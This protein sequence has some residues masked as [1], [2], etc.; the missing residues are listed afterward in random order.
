MSSD[1]QVHMGKPRA[2]MFFRPKP[3]G[4]IDPAGEVGW[5][6][7]R[8]R[9]RRRERLHD[10]GRASGVHPHH[11]DAIEAGDLTRLPPRRDTLRMLE[12]YALHLGFDPEPLLKHYA[13][14]LPQQNRTTTRRMPG[15]A[16]PFGSAEII[17]FPL[18]NRLIDATKGNG[19]IVA[20]ICGA[21]FLFAAASWVLSP[22]SGSSGEAQALRSAPSHVKVEGPATEVSSITSLTEELMKGDS[23]ETRDAAV[24]PVSPDLP[25]PDAEDAPSLPVDGIA[26][27]IARETGTPA[28]RNAAA[29]RAPES[30]EQAGGG[31]LYGS[32]NS[33]SRLVLHAKAKV[34]IRIEDAHGKVILTKTLMPGDSYRVPNRDGLMVIARD[35]GLISYSIDGIDKGQLGNPGEILV[36]R[37]LDLRLLT[38][39]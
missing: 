33:D 2:S 13:Q 29:N 12:A 4:E 28:R 11:L 8:E 37:S 1:S 30:E 27:L 39:G 9:E 24:G 19:G 23:A 6:L 3:D 32:E 17:A 36:G 18:L 10:A 22:S 14:F 34:W 7:Q 26:E 21:V 20:S 35:G 38:E 25:E 31:R 5:F 15:T 16:R